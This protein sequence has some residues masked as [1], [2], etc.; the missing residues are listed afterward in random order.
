M[1]WKIS[2]S[3]DALKFIEKEKI[4]ETEIIDIIRKAIFVFQGEDFNID[5]KKLKGRWLGFYRIRIGKIR[6]LTEF[7]FDNLSVFIERIDW[8]GR[9]YN[10]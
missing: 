9:A 10:R 8:R 2:F 3:R 1:N 5:I 6:I 4:A 7:D